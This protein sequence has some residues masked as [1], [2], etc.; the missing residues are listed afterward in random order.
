MVVSTAEWLRVGIAYQGDKNEDELLLAVLVLTIA[1][2]KG[3][4][5]QP[6]NN[7]KPRR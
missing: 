1:G 7:R 6:F 3:P 2:C 4:N 5:V